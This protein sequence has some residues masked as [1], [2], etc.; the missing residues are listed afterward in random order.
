MAVPAAAQRR[1]PPH[2]PQNRPSPSSAEDRE[3]RALFEAGVEAY[4][5][6]R[7]DRALDYFRRA[8][9]LSRRPQL[10]YN[11]GLA[12]DRLGSAAVA[13]E[14]YERYLRELPNAAERDAVLERI[15]RLREATS[16]DA[17][18][19]DGPSAS[20]ERGASEAEHAVEDAVDD[21]VRQA[22]PVVSHG[23]GPM[24]WVLA[25][26]G[27]ALLLTGGA[28]LAVALVNQGQLADAEDG[29]T[30]RSY[31]GHYDRANVFGSVGWA[32][33]GVGALTAAVSVVLLATSGSER[34]DN[35]STPRPALALRLGPGGLALR[36]TF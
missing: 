2:P 32:L 18:V 17:T 5:A 33:L 1:P 12:A 36:G 10:L 19:V 21:A 22:A 26:G 9:E 28:L 27:G 8:H 31:E 34:G 23:P 29:A 7:Y 14:A 16:P 35:A 6:A 4:N 3:A 15:E 20:V 24:P 13:I 25:L 11:L 30:W